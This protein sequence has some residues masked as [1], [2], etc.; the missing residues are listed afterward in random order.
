MKKKTKIVATISDR[1]CEVAFL[2]E[3]YEA[4]MDVV[5][6][7]TAHQTHDDA[8]KVINNV[9]VVS[10]K[11]GILIDTK[12]PEIRTTESKAKIP[13]VYGD[14][15]NVKGAPN[16]GT[17]KDCIC[18][19][20]DNFVEDVPVYSRI[21]IDD[22][23]IELL[24]VGKEDDVL[25]CEVKNDGNIRG[26]KSINIPSVHIKL[27]AL[28]EKDKGFIRFAAQNNVDFIAH[29]FVRTKEDAI[30]VQDIID[31]VG[32][33]IKIIAK[34][35]NQQGVENIHEILDHVYGVMVARGD[36]AIEIPAERIPLVQ[37]KLVSI[38]RERRKPV[39]VATQ[40]L[41]SMINSPRPTRAEVSDIAN[42]CLDRT[43]AIMLSGE[44]AFGKYP[45]KSVETMA[46]IVLETEMDGSTFV[47]TDY[48]VDH[49]VTAYLSKAAVKT[50]MRLDTKALI[51]DTLTGRTI[52]GLAAYRGKTLIFVQ[53][54]SK[55]VMRELSLSYG[56]YCDYIEIK[57]SAHDFL[58]VTLPMLMYHG[59]FEK[60]DL[61]VVLAGNYGTEQ[62]AS[63][64]E[65][66]TA[67]IM[68]GSFYKA[69]A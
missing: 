69:S 65:I 49:K 33:D 53:C 19:S 3:L 4:G 63:F 48:T 40:M 51:A 21:L 17:T 41:H 22:G 39:I 35:E 66:S 42:A 28:S 32:S 64:I 34:I 18:V 12:G 25:K 61:I 68:L 31:E 50:S 26:R 24:V 15:I 67:E 37:K 1:D 29:S 13:V 5:R 2:R 10:D 52:L 6:L 55:R 54:Y 43:D 7:N 30:A 36:L 27:P 44:T 20:Y 23:H 60:E 9:R 46:R 57:A 62:G 11:I 16:E 58:K 14:I 45:V 8:L 38:C 47:D 59:H 56:V